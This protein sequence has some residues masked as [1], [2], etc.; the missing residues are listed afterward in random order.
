LISLIILLCSFFSC[1]SLILNTGILYIDNFTVNDPKEWV[2]CEDPVCVANAMYDFTAVSNEELSFKA[3][4]KI[5][6]APQSLQSKNAPGWLIA[7]DNR[8]VGLIPANYVNI[9]GQLKKKPE[10]ENNKDDI[11]PNFIQNKTS[12]E[13]TTFTN[14]QE[15]STSSQSTDFSTNNIN[16]LF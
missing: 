16:N 3:G 1:F 5:W 13:E 14:I 15:P 10:S 2:K 8:N 6:L 7:T 9:V 12:N 4:Q 11:E